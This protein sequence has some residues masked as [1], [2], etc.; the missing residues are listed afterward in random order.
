MKLLKSSLLLLLPF[1]TASPIPSEDKD[2]IPGRYIVTLKD[3]IT[4]ED[5]EYHKSWVTSVHRSNLAAAT[6]AGRPRLETEGIRKFFQIHK[7]NAYSGAFDDQTAEDIRRNPYVKSVTP[8]RKV[9]LADTVVQENA[10]YNL[11]HMSSKGRHSFTYRYD[12][13]A[14]EGIWAYVLDTGINVDH[15]EFEGRAD[16]GYN[17]IKNVS[18]TDNF[19]HGSF[20]AGIIAAKTYGVAKKATVISAKA[21]DTGSST[22][23]YIFDAYNWVVKNITDSGRQKKSVVNMSI[24]SAKYQPFDDAVDNAFEA[25]ITTVVAAG[26]DGVSALTEEVNDFSINMLMQRDASNN[27]PASAANAITVASIRFDNGRSLFSNYG[28]VVDIFAPGERIVSCWI[29]GNDATRKADGTSVSSPHVAGLV[30]YLMAIEDLPDPA[31]VTKRVLDLSI[32]DLV[33]DPGEGSPNRI[34]YNGIQEMNETVIA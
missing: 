7:M 26:N 14:G 22:Y 34:A 11:G 24:S 25:G 3:G 16:S 20:T 23:D 4:Q 30:A 27:T 31:A 13:T 9:Y 28:S 6:A 15:I 33:R 32:P 8:D 12:S 5:I 1:V 19:G 10:G 18:N 29:G 17:A 2:I 21:F